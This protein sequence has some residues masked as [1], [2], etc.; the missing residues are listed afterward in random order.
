MISENKQTENFTEQDLDRLLGL[1]THNDL[2]QEKKIETTTESSLEQELLQE[3]EPE[4]TKHSFSQSPWAKLG[5]VGLI[6]G[7]IF[8][9]VGLIL[10]SVMEGTSNIKIG[11][12]SNSNSQTQ[13]GLDLE[14]QELTDAEKIGILKTEIAISSAQENQLKSFDQIEP[15]PKQTN[16]QKETLEQTEPTSKPVTQV[17]TP[18][19]QTYIPPKQTYTPQPVEQV[20][21]QPPPKLSWHELAALGNY[22]SY[23]PTSVNTTPNPEENW[24][25]DLQMI[26][27]PTQQAPTPRLA[28]EEVQITTKQSVPSA[29]ARLYPNQSQ[30]VAYNYNSEFNKSEDANFQPDQNESKISIEAEEVKSQISQNWLES[31][32]YEAEE[33]NENDYKGEVV[34]T[35]K[36]ITGYP[37]NY[38]IQPYDHQMTSEEEIFLGKSKTP[39]REKSILQ[40]GQQV[41]GEIVTPLVWSE[42]DSTQ[43]KFVV[44]LQEDLTD[45]TGS[46]TV[47]PADTLLVFEIDSIQDNGFV[48]SKAIAFI[49]NG[50]E[51]LLPQGVISLRGKQGMPLIAKADRNENTDS[52]D[53]LLFITGAAAQ[54]GEVLNRPESTT[55]TNSSG[56]GGFYQNSTVNNGDSSIVGAILDGGL[57][58]LHEQLEK[59]DTEPTKQSTPLW[60][61]EAEQK[62]MIFV[63]ETFQM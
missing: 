1:E 28:Q 39:N 49:R 61:V 40:V 35:P 33:L 29:V 50:T 37:R 54:I 47:L 14:D 19:K 23:Q 27:Q 22:G 15:E 45:F 59:K 63:N 32:V 17:K 13:S 51:Y 55:I 6:L 42:E 8:L 16:L 18:P 25:D 21:T 5:L 11:G 30:L 24:T 26:N 57:G 48:V 12:R 60:V 46:Q 43:Q 34:S 44:R 2:S 3:L 41:E 62:V 58:T 31:S 53:R 56:S 38:N 20:K 52:R 4:K 7:V 9:I 10:N 36:R